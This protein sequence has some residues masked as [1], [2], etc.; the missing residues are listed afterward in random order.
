[1]NWNLRTRSTLLHCS[2]S[3]HLNPL[4][5]QSCFLVALYLLLWSWDDIKYDAQESFEL[6]MF[7]CSIFVYLAYRFL[8]RKEKV[9]NVNQENCYENT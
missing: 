4:A 1:M 5:T 6:F 9:K 8:T 3:R 7:S 2:L